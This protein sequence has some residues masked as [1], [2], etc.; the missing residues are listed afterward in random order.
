MQI[1]VDDLKRALDEHKD[2]VLLD[3]RTE[4][5]VARGK[6]A[7]SINVPIQEISSKIESIVPDKSRLVYVYCLS[8]SRSAI[9][10]EEMIKKGYRNVFNV[11]GGILSWRTKHY[12]TV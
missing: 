1:S 2:L 10:V 3:V 9:A 5:E 8:G 7:G 12:P 6:I 11:E 4:G